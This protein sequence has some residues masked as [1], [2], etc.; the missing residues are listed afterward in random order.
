MFWQEKALSRRLSGKHIF[1]S[2][3]PMCTSGEDKGE[4]KA[5]SWWSCLDHWAGVLFEGPDL[6][7]LPGVLWFCYVCK[8][9]IP[10]KKPQLSNR[11]HE[12][13]L[14]G[15]LGSN[16]HLHCYLRFEALIPGASDFAVVSPLSRSVVSLPSSGTLMLWRPPRGGIWT[17]CTLHMLGADLLQFFQGTLWGLFQ[18]SLMPQTQ[19]RYTEWY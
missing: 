13:Q 1:C 5:R 9:P 4:Y 17:D 15:F 7:C 14:F 18:S 2:D 12:V 8:L 10:K 6:T 16:S 19:C 11:Q 3:G